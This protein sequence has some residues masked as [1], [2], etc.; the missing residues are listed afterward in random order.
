MDTNNALDLAREKGLDLVEVSP[1]AE[2]P[3]CK[4]LDWGAHQYQQDRAARK[5]KTKQRASEIKGIRI[6]FKIGAHDLEMKIAQALKFLER[7][8]RV[9]LEIILRGRE[10]RF[11]D[12]ALEK[13]QQFVDLLGDKAYQDG[14]I[15]KAGKRMS[16]LITKK[17]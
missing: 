3:V 11:K 7:G 6:S 16:L 1:N 4:I 12:K 9:K 5:Q 14:E 13:M 15:S 10:N 2:P 17:K 8:N